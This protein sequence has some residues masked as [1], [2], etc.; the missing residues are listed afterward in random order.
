MQ[1][2]RLPTELC[3]AII[4]AIRP[5]CDDWFSYPEQSG[6]LLACSLTCR[7]WRPRAQLNLWKA[8]LLRH[9]ERILPQ[10]VAAARGSPERLAPL[11]RTM[12]LRPFGEK[13]PLEL[14]MGGPALPNLRLLTMEEVTW[15]PFPPRAS[16][17]RMPLLASVCDLRLSACSFHTVKDLLGV[18]WACASL[19]DLVV[20]RCSFK[21][22][23]FTEADAARLSTM[24]KRPGACEKLTRLK[25]F[26][27]PFD[28]AHAPSGDVFG[29]AVTE[30][31]VVYSDFADSVSLSRILLSFT[32]LQALTV[33]GFLWDA[34][35]WMDGPA[36]IP[37]LAS[38][39]PN[40]SA[41]HILTLH[42]E[43]SYESEE[44]TLDAICGHE[45]ANPADEDHTSL[46]ALLPA[47]TRLEVRIAGIPAS[48]GGWW[49]AQIA[50][51]LPS[52]RSVLVFE[53]AR[54]KEVGLW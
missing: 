18:V 49:S 51:R 20:L 45:A 19:A 36:L 43:T 17:M 48:S 24:R 54:I 32:S 12:C 52:M 29:S 42:I 40:Q 50:E 9:S 41:L 47:L 28:H 46:R 39:L 15:V 33:T 37:A 10:F 38:F 22:E 6:P 25:L 11:V 34:S 5:T 53:V 21:R 3:E 26:G 31:D 7:A 13:V 8:V 2:S 4:D 30:L 23:Q 35:T 16:R 14:L 1:S 44:R 27:H